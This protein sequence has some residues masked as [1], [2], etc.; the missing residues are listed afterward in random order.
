MALTICH[1]ESIKVQ[2]RYNNI[3]IIIIIIIITYFAQSYRLISISISCCMTLD[4]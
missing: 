2:I 1:V 4:H 3:I